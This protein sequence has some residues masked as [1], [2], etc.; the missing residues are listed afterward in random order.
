MVLGDGESVGGEDC[1]V[2]RTIGSRGGGKNGADDGL[3]G[4]C[5]ETGGNGGM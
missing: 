4:L 2:N 1:G 5:R 3:G